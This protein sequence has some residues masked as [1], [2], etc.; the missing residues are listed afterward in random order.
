[1]AKVFF[2]A[3][4]HF[5]HANV[6]K[7]CSRPFGSVEEMNAELIR[8][9][10]TVVGSEDAV[11]HLGDF[12]L[13]KNSE[14]P[15][16]LHRLSGAKK[17]LILGNHDRSARQMLEG[18]FT[19]VHEKLEWNGWMLQHHPIATN[20]KLLC[21]HIHEKWK[22][23]GWVINVGVDVWDFTPRTIEELIKAEESPREFKCRYCGTL[24]KRLQ[25]NPGHRDGRCISM[26]TKDPA[27]KDQRS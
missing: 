24:L 25:N 19:E 8:R 27:D 9:W 3:D 10:N 4:T 21:G 23:I 7:Y 13:G 11:Y 18:G 16:I 6:I 1:M 12:A 15:G 5:N 2:T 14:W 20:R 22:R 26:R 17:I